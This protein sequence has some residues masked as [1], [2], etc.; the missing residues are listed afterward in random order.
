LVKRI[1]LCQSAYR[2]TRQIAAT[3]LRG[4]VS[5]FKRITSR[6]LFASNSEAV[7]LVSSQGKTNEYLPV[8]YRI[9]KT[10]TQ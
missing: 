3:S 9:S 4:C 8:E 7:V 1:D 10:H 5:A 2:D 6:H